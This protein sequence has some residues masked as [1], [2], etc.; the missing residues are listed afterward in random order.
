MLSI[1]SVTARIFQLLG[2]LVLAG[3]AFLTVAFL[4]DGDRIASLFCA[5]M[6]LASAAFIILAGWMRKR[7]KA[8]SDKF[9]P[10]VR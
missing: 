1:Y 6:T 8:W 2:A 3:A 4:R 10:S 7:M 5:T 9:P